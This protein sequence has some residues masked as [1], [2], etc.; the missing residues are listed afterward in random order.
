MRLANLDTSHDPTHSS[1]EIS[2]PLEAST[3]YSGICTLG[4]RLIELIEPIA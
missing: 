1:S 2:A 3:L 4:V